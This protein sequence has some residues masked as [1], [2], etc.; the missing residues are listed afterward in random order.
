MTAA[1]KLAARA[2]SH[3][4]TVRYF[5]GDVWVTVS[6]DAD[7]HQHIDVEDPAAGVDAGERVPWPLNEYR[8]DPGHHPKFPPAWWD[9]RWPRRLPPPRMPG[10][11]LTVE[12]GVR[13][14]SWSWRE[15]RGWVPLHGRSPEQETPWGQETKEAA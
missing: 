9:G 4:P 2:I 12:I 14:A 3:T 8:A 11:W 1:A 5:D 6:W 7:G 10:V 13:A 15:N